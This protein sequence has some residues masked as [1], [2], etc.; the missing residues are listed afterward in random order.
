MWFKF[1]TEDFL[2]VTKEFSAEEIGIYVQL[3]AL[4]MGTG[5]VRPIS[6]TRAQMIHYC[7]VPKNSIASLIH[8]LQSTFR[9]T[10]EGYQLVREMGFLSMTEKPLMDTRQ[11]A[12]PSR[13]ATK[14]QATGGEI[15]YYER[16][17]QGLLR[18]LTNSGLEPAKAARILVKESAKKA[19][20][21]QGELSELPRNERV[22]ES[23][24][25]HRDTKAVLIKS[26]QAL[27]IPATTKWGT[28]EISAAVVGKLGYLPGH[29]QPPTLPPNNAEFVTA[30]LMELMDNAAST[31]QLGQIEGAI[32]APADDAIA[33]GL[34]PIA[35]KLHP[36]VNSR[37][38]IAPLAPIAPEIAPF[39]PPGEEGDIGGGGTTSVCIMETSL[40]IWGGDN[41][42]SRITK[43]KGE[44]NQNQ[45]TGG[46]AAARALRQRGIPD[47]NPS[48]PD[49]LRLL[50]QGVTPGELADAAEEAVS[51]GKGRFAYVLAVVD[52]RRRAAAAA[53]PLPGKAMMP[54]GETVDEL[55]RRIFGED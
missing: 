55:D 54:S 50:A 34:H 17:E 49:L 2:A 44:I 48:H 10:P 32:V 5:S 25:R 15:D 18:A 46:G 30:E 29:M 7:K 23:M 51:R 22:K 8:V 1:N 13:R 14:A 40:S 9:L 26:A 11:P 33:P 27:G 6:L 35:P 12:L 38:N 47:A 42:E 43:N 3:V 4:V 45:I 41:T 52:A 16:N 53:A 21:L 37:C 39:P 20:R 31:A 28:K 36:E 19:P 24:R